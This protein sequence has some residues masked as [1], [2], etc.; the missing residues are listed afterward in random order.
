MLGVVLLY[1]GAVLFLNG[2]WLYGLA[3]Q[4]E[5]DRAAAGAG[6]AA[7]P[8]T[9]ASYMIENREVAIMNIFTG[10][11]NSAVAATAL[12]YGLVTD[13]ATFFALAGFV[14][15]FGFTYL[16]VAAN[17]FLGASGRGL[18]WFCLFVAITAVPTGA[19]VLDRGGWS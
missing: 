2:I 12:V 8:R 19:I 13:D 4:A 5:Q 1:V 6:E 7:V 10:A 11:V 15:L 17:Q 9:P 18:G 3:R 16:W 14:L